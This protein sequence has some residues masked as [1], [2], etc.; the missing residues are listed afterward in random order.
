MVAVV[1]HQHHAATLDLQLAV[2]LE[3]P[4]HALEAGQPLDDGFVGD[5]L[6]GSDDDGRQEFSTLCRPGMF[7]ETSSGSRPGATR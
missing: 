3:A 6:V 4:A 5:A 7:T 1:V 2:D